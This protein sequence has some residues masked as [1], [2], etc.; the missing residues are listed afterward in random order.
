MY[1][2]LPQDSQKSFFDSSFKNKFFTGIRGLFGLSNNRNDE[3]IFLDCIGEDVFDMED[4]YNDL[5]ELFPD[6]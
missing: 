3:S 6:D 2:G 5:P 1:K 4:E